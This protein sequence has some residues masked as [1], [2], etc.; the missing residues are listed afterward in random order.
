MAAPTPSRSKHRTR[1]SASSALSSLELEFREWPGGVV[2][3]FACST[4]AARGSQVQ[5]LGVDLAL[6]IKACC[7]SVPYD[8]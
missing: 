1:L 4:L 6:L 8:K 7:G 2:V 3:Q 5:I